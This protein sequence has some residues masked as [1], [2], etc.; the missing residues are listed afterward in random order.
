MGKLHKNYRFIAWLCRCNWIGFCRV[1]KSHRLD[2]P[3]QPRFVF[4]FS[5]LA[6]LCGVFWRFESQHFM[7]YE[8]LGSEFAA[9]NYFDKSGIA[10]VTATHKA[11]HPRRKFYRLCFRLFPIPMGI[12]LLCTWVSIFFV[13]FSGGTTS[14]EPTANITVK[15]DAP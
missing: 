8:T 1:N 6:M 10:P 4:L 3:S 12:F 13:F 14:P 9:K 5:A 11:N 15:R 2:Q 7:E